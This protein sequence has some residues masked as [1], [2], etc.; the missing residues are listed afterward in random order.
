M[1]TINSRLK[2]LKYYLILSLFGIHKGHNVEN[3]LNL[4]KSSD[5]TSKQFQNNLSA[6]YFHNFYRLNFQKCVSNKPILN[7]EFA[8][9]Y[10]DS[11]VFGV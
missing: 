10:A 1:I 7:V 4:L 11:V 9:M 5:M 8:Y 2:S 6:A 3:F